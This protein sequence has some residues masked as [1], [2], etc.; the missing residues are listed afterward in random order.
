MHSDTLH[1]VSA[2]IAAAMC[3]SENSK[4]QP[5]PKIAT[6]PNISVAQLPR[7]RQMHEVEWIFYKHALANSANVSR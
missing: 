4:V 6:Q 1:A 3:T 2:S 7:M 5:P